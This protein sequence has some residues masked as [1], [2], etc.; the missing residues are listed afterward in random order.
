MTLCRRQIAVSQFHL[1]TEK[2]K[3]PI[4]PVNPV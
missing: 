2:E 3:N 4:N 1:E